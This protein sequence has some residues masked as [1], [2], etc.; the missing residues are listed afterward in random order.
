PPKPP[1]LVL[2]KNNQWLSRD[3]AGTFSLAAVLIVAPRFTAG[4]HGSSAL[5]RCDT[6]MSA[7]PYPPARFE[8]RYRL[9]PSRE[10]AGPT[11]FAAELIVG[12]RLIG[13]D[14]S[15]NFGIAAAR[16]EAMTSEKTIPKIGRASCR[17]RVYNT[18]G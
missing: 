14:H 8:P 6:Q 11:S 5:A 2:A 7:M 1:D 16:F 13:V 9:R 15:E 17:E 10:I 3:R 18:E 4:P 12:P